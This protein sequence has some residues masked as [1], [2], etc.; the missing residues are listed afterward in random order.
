MKHVSMNR[1]VLSLALTVL[2]GASLAQTGADAGKN[3]YQSSCASCHGVS[4]KGD[5]GLTAFLIKAPTDLTTLAKRNGGVFPN[6][7]V[8]DM[9]DGRS[10]VE[11]GPHGAREMPVWG[12]VYRLNPDVQEPAWYARNRIASLLDYLARIQEK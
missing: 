9:I 7:R 12:S 6:Q 1:L 4:G 8:W 3:E 2:S 10:S 5:G 11:I